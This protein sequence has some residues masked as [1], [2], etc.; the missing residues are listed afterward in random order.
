MSEGDLDLDMPAETYLWLD[1]HNQTLLPAL[2]TDLWKDLK[3]VNS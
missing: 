2:S 3:K 1:L